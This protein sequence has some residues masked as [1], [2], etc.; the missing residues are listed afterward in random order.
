MPSLVRASLIV[1]AL[2]ATAAC[3]NKPLVTPDRTLPAPSMPIRN[4]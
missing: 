4:R 3:T 2:L 1:L